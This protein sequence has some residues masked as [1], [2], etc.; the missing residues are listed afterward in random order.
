MPV[1]L[2]NK[3]YIV[4]L[5]SQLLSYLGDYQHLIPGIQL[6]TTRKIE[7]MRETKSPSFEAVT[8]N[9][10]Q[11]LFAE[12]I[13]E[14]LQEGI[15]ENSHIHPYAEII[16]II[17]G[18]GKLYLD[19]QISELEINCM[20]F[21][22]PGQVHKLHCDENIK[23][24]VLSISK[25][26]LEK[27][28]TGIQT[29]N[30]DAFINPLLN[31]GRIKVHDNYSGDFNDVIE[32]I[33]REIR[34]P[35][36][37]ANEILFRYFSIFLFY[38]GKQESVGSGKMIQN[39]NLQVY[40][41][42]KVLVDKHYK[43]KKLVSEYASE[44]NLTPNY[45]NEIIKKVTGHSAG[46]LIRQRIVLEAKRYAIHSQVCM[47]EIGYNLGFSDMAHFSKF[48]KSVVGSN[49]TDFKNKQV[50]YALAS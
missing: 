29:S 33:I 15:Q 16:W 6:D 27:D 23:G 30:S 36:E 42:F 49:F 14:F 45:L 18:S 41:Q 20:Y 48:F 31:Y 40:D 8:K 50:G 9:S 38:L 11:F 26:L 17:E 43:T 1:L 39:R 28:A 3:R 22:R 21:I 4:Y 7:I 47:K 34:Q 35:K 24:Y 19:M 5:F 37:Y 25:T 13:K 12:H 2:L 10:N 44:L 46:Y 32:R